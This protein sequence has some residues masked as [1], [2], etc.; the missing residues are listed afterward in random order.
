MLSMKSHHN[1]QKMLLVSFVDMWFKVIND[2]SLI[3]GYRFDKLTM[4]CKYTLMNP[5]MFDYT[6]T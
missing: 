5:L 2:F 6:W 1:V 3:C 4:M